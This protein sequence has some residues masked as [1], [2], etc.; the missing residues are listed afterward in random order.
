MHLPGSMETSKFFCKGFC[1][2]FS[3]KEAFS[4]SAVEMSPNYP[5][6]HAKASN[7]AAAWLQSTL[8]LLENLASVRTNQGVAGY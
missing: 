4:K 8:C 7:S 5:Y 2:R 6:N 3:A 1:P